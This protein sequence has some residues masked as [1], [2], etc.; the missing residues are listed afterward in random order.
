HHFFLLGSC[1]FTF[2]TCQRVNVIR[3]AGQLLICF[4]FF[5]QCLL[6]QRGVLRLAELVSECNHGS[7]RSDFVM[8]HSLGGAD[9]CRIHHCPFKI[10]VHDFA[11]FFD[12]TLHPHA[13]CSL[14]AL[15]QC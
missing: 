14:R 13:L 15:V 11:T 4:L 12:Q 9:Q 6:E 2:T 1:A 10:F 3:Q 8:L 5:F 7:I